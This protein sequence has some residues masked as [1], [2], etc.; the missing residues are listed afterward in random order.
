MF[1]EIFEKKYLIGACR[2]FETNH[3]QLAIYH[4]FFFILT[5]N[6]EYLLSL[7]YIVIVNLFKLSSLEI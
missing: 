4:I 6:N 3:N 7:L 2:Y 1:F 5:M